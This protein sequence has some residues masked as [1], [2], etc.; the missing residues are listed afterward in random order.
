MMGRNSRRTDNVQD[1]AS[2]FF[3]RRCAFLCPRNDVAWWIEWVLQLV[4]YASLQPAGM[5]GRSL[6]NTAE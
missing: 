5:M 6:H 1:L 3:G 4:N 2:N